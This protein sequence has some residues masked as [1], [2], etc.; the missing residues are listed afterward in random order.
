MV[1]SKRTVLELGGAGLALEA[2][3]ANE[4]ADARRM[5]RADMQPGFE[6]FKFRM[7]QEKIDFK[8]RENLFF[9]ACSFWEVRDP[10]RGHKR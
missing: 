6:F 9:G 1:L 4:T 3:V 7:I 8:L 5:N 2:R 10:F